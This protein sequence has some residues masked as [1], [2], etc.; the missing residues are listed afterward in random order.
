[1][2]SLGEKQ[3]QTV[4]LEQKQTVSKA[5]LRALGLHVKDFLKNM[6]VLFCNKGKQDFC[7]LINTDVA[8]QVTTEDVG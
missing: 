8:D 6:I 5:R 3:T 1:M 7:V 4:V 2:R